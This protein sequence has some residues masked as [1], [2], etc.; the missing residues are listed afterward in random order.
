MLRMEDARALIATVEGYGVRLRAQGQEVRL[1]GTARLPP[2]LT[3][4]LTANTA[5]VLKYLQQRNA[6]ALARQSMPRLRILPPQELVPSYRISSWNGLM[7]KETG[8]ESS[9]G[10]NLVLRRTAPLDIAAFELAFDS[11]LRRHDVLQATLLNIDGR[12]WLRYG[13]AVV[14]GFSRTSLCHLPADERLSTGLRLMSEWIYE[15]FDLY[16]GPLFRAFLIELGAADHLFGLVVHHFLADRLSAAL[17]FQDLMRCY[18]SALAGRPLLNEAP[19][20]QYRDYLLCMHEWFATA[21]ARTHLEYWQTRLASA[22]PSGVNAVLGGSVSVEPLTINA[23]LARG[24]NDVARALR[25]HTYA[26]LLAAHKV[27]LARGTSSNDITIGTVTAGREA[28]ELQS[29][30]GNLADRV[31]YRT[32]L[33]GN[34][35]FAELVERARENMLEAS[36]YQFIRYDVLLEH[37]ATLGHSRLLMPFLSFFPRSTMPRAAAQAGT[38]QAQAL[39]AIP[40]TAR[41]NRDWLYWIVLEEREDGIRGQIRYNG[42]V[43]R[44]LSAGFL[45]VLQEAVADS[46][47]R[48][49][50]FA[51]PQLS[52]KERTA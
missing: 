21:G 50:S 33:E 45:A 6:A 22:P 49:M 43:I 32:S 41:P 18:E 15:P 14:R 28:I 17:L 30:I 3:A 9:N 5:A 39:P 36:L 42:P 31:F 44:G 20:L 25:T 51:A 2:E 38:W 23:S 24:V 40:S 46:R 29:V 10:P 7:R 16:N 4:R 11:V 37:L 26:V 13:K 1:D 34:L 19:R 35:T 47:R 52:R 12:P 27:M 8:L 48:L